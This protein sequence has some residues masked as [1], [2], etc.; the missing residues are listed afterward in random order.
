MFEL[1][2]PPVFEEK[3]ANDQSNFYNFCFNRFYLPFSSLSSQVYSHVSISKLFQRFILHKLCMIRQ[4][5][6][7]V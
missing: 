6:N 3:V 7:C 2:N 1:V 5:L 4:E